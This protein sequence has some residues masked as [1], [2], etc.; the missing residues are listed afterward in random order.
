[1]NNLKFIEEYKKFIK[2]EKR[3]SPA[4]VK[5]Y[6]RDINDLIELMGNK[7]LETSLKKHLYFLN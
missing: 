5:S 4:S 6:L 7:N 1:M 2:F 3:L